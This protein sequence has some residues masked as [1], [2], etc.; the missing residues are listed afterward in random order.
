MSEA[1]GKN[2][3]IT[4]A[5]GG[6]GRAL[7]LAYAEPE[8]TL[9]LIGRD[10]SRLESCAQACRALGAQVVTAQI[11]VR[12]AAAMQAWLEAFDEAQAIDL[13]IAN[14]GVASTLASPSDWEALDRTAKIIDINLYGAMHAVLPVI[15]H[16]RTRR[17]G[18]IV[19]MSSIAALRG[20]A[21]SPAYCAS[22]AA[23][24]SWGDSVRPVLA[25]DGIHLA[26]VLPGFV[27]TAMSDVF[28]GD[29]P[30]I[31]SADKAA[32]FIRRKLAARRAEI[33]FPGHLA[34]GMRVLSLLPAAIADIILGRLSYLPR[35]GN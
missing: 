30:C 28:P 16:M 33:A 29:K 31:W 24:K 14:A 17:R 20:M 26:V 1:A 11:D 4:G 27:K 5:S 3:V 22:K 23:L 35:E 34:V 2:I 12:D 8:V 21:I 25:R 13:L 7:A 19:L 15:D 10:A 6:I 9:G 18:Q 32:H